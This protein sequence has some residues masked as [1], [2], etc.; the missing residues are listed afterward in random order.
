MTKYPI[1]HTKF[2]TAKINKKGHYQIT[3]RKEGNG[4]K[5]LHR[6]MNYP[7][8]PLHIELNGGCNND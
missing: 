8:E 6:L 7:T 2:G 1:L 4:G 3:S 5:L